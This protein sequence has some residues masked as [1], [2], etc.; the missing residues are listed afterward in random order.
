MKTKEIPVLLLAVAPF[1]AA[2]VLAILAPF[3]GSEG[4]A[5]VEMSLDMVEEPE[6]H[7]AQERQ[8]LTEIADGHDLRGEVP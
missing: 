7:T 1:L 3:A 2:A 8:I 5:A 6:Q 4:R